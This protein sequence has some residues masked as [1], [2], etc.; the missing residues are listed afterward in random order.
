WPRP[1]ANSSASSVRSV[2]RI[3]PS[4]SAEAGATGSAAAPALATGSAA[5]GTG[6]AGL[7]TLGTGSAAA[8]AGL[9]LLDTGSSAFEGLTS[10]GLNII[11]SLLGAREL[12]APAE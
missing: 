5:L 3:C 4:P 10:G 6:S 8:L 2:S 1:P 11:D 12:Q 9:E 7:G